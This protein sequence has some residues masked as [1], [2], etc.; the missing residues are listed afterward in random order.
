M[1]KI[2]D[3]LEPMANDI[4]SNLIDYLHTIRGQTTRDSF[5][6]VGVNQSEN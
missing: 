3:W 4:V 5:S 2:E 1:Y 6:K